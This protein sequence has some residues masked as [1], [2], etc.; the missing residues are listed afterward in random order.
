MTLGAESIALSPTGTTDYVHLIHYRTVI[1]AVAH[2]KYKYLYDTYSTDS[3]TPKSHDLPPQVA[4]ILS[5]AN[6]A[7]LSQDNWPDPSNAATLST[8]QLPK[9]LYLDDP[10]SVYQQWFVRLRYND[11]RF[12]DLPMGKIANQ[13]GWVNSQVG[14]VAC[15]EDILT[16]CI[17]P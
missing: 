15:V 2:V 16:V 11:G 6:D 9:T 12:M 14:A 13:S 5:T 10:N 4:N 7:T 17:T 3:F 8:S 1:D